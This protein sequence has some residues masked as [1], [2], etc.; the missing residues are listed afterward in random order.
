MKKLLILLTLILLATPVLAQEK[1]EDKSGTNPIK[2]THDIRIYNEYTWLNTPGD[3]EQNV[4]T[5]E[6]RQPIA[7]GKWQFRTRIRHTS[8]ELDL[9]D[10][11]ID[12]F[13]ESG[14][15]EVDFR[16]L[17][18]PYF[19]K[20]K[21]QAFAYGIETFLPTA[22]D[23]LGSERL[24]FGPQ[25]FYAKFN[26]FGLKGLAVFPGYQ[27][28]FSVYED[29]GVDSLH[30]GLI[31]LYVLWISG[32]KQYWALLDPQIIIDYEEDELYS[33]TDLEIGMMVDKYIDSKGHS[34]YLRPSIGIG[35]D[36]PTDGSIEVGYKIVW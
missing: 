31:D 9:N 2:F 1:K 12:E 27:Q 19:D 36:R 23:G 33:V 35:G 7:G 4:T 34:V 3:S 24:S 10:D 8:I 13:D 28:K 32:N 16:L 11:G 25:V 26:P 21:G 17:T 22:E 18:V 20:S 30:Q 14:L 15:G 5:L 6:Y 29:N